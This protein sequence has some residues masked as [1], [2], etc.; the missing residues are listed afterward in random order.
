MLNTQKSTMLF[1]VTVL[2]IA[3]DRLNIIYAAFIILT[4][5]VLW[6]FYHDLNGHHFI[7]LVLVTNI[8]LI[9]CSGS[10]LHL[11]WKFQMFFVLSL[12]KDFILIFQK[13]WF[14]KFAL[15]SKRV[16]YFM[17][18]QQNKEEPTETSSDFMVYYYF[19][20]IR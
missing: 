13:V 5:H 18:A 16:I 2:F 19:F 4:I 15:K 3:I 10:Y 9:T 1:R 12:F 8:W 20:N 7:T 6:K 11:F 17:M 14:L